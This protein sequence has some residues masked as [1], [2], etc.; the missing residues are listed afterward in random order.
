MVTKVR[1]TPV[2]GAIRLIIVWPRGLIGSSLIWLAS[3]LGLKLLCPI[4]HTL[5]PFRF[6]V[7]WLK[8]IDFP[9]FIR[10]KWRDFLDTASALPFLRKDLRIWN[11]CVFGHIHLR[12]SKL[13]SSLTLTKR[14]SSRG[15]NL[16]KT[17][18][19]WVTK[20]LLS[21]THEV[22]TRLKYWRRQMEPGLNGEIW[23]AIKCMKAL[24]SLDVDGYQPIFFHECW[25][26]V[27]NFKVLS[28]NAQGVAG[29]DFML[30]LKDLIRSHDPTILILVETGINGNQADKVCDTVGFDDVSRVKDIGFRGGVW[31]MWRWDRNR[32]SEASNHTGARLDRALYNVDWRT[33]FE[34]AGVNILL[35][36]SQTTLQFYSNRMDFREIYPHLGHFAWLLH[37]EFQQ[38][39]AQ[40]LD[41]GLPLIESLPNLAAH[42]DVWNKNVFRKMFRRKNRVWRRLEGVQS[43]ICANP[44]PRLLRLEAR[45]RKELNEVLQQ[46]HVLWVQKARTDAMRDEDKNT[47][48][49]HACVV[50]RRRRN[51]IYGLQDNDGN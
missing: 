21:S 37:N 43:R 11:R 3:W 49:F 5:R 27:G 16:E 45:L 38:F 33:L 26:V 42:L 25:P 50:V 39:L 48:Y 6:E 9:P 28:W 20:T 15:R 29:R 46:I 41:Q 19:R 30:T 18:L 8:H 31:V 23:R 35:Q 7:A 13:I 4:W 47:R 32:G 51:M 10:D 40:H 36:Q 22:V 24:K 14:T 44:S 17:G 12:I 34:E 1:T 2:V